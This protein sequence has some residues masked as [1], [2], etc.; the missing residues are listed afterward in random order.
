M[1]PTAQENNILSVGKIL[2]DKEQSLKERFRAL[3]TLKNIGGEIAIKEITRC[4]NDPSAL[5]KHE[6]AYCLG[7]M[8]DTLAIPT[9]VEVLKDENQ[10]P[11]VRHE[12]GDYEFSR[13]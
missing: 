3:F 12:A 13:I 8:Q 11:M 10:E 2:N 4:F 7:Q 1:L 9:L 6:L 5:L